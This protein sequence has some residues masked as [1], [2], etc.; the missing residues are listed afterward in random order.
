MYIHNSNGY[1]THTHETKTRSHKQNIVFRRCVCVRACAYVVVF[2]ARSII[3]LSTHS[4]ISDQLA[5]APPAEEVD[6]PHDLHGPLEVQTLLHHPSEHL[7]CLVL[8]LG[9][10]EGVLYVVRVLHTRQLWDA[11]RAHLVA[12]EKRAWLCGR[13]F[14]SARGM[15]FPPPPPPRAE[16]VI[17]AFE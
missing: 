10:E 17:R 15:V 9:Q 14:V 7:L 12:V 2:F 13:S 11:R 1:N 6:L 16:L 8:W 4:P 3:C 5:G